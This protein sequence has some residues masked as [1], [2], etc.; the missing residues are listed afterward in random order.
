MTVLVLYCRFFTIQIAED[1][2][3]LDNADSFIR[4]ALN[5]GVI[6]SPDNLFSLDDIIESFT[7]FQLS[8]N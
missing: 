4:A 2:E 1:A 5:A 6:F 7:L 8:P 3:C